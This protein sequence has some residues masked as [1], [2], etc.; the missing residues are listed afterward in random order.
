MALA[1]GRKTFRIV[2]VSNFEQLNT[3]VFSEAECGRGH[4]LLRMHRKAD[5]TLV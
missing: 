5:V 4:V 1:G 2:V 3:G